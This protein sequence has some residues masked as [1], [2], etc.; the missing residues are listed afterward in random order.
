VVE[1]AEDGKANVAVLALL[2]HTLDVPRRHLQVTAGR[3]SRDKL[4]EISGLS[5]EAAHERLSAAAAR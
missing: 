1:P 2:A 3:A 5:S 4:V